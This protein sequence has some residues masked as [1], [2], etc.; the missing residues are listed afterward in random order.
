MTQLNLNQPT[1]QFGTAEYGVTPG[2]DHC[3][4]CHQPLAG[5]YYS[6]RGKA[7]CPACAETARQKGLNDSHSA[8]V[9]G[10]LF[11]VGAAVAGLIGYAVISIVLQ[12][13]VI[14]YMSFGVGWLVGVAMMKGSG[15]VGGR[16]Y[17]IAAVLLTYAA[18]SI[19]AIPIWIY[20]ARQ[21]QPRH[22][23]H[24]KVQQEQQQDDASDPQQSPDS[25]AAR[26]QLSLGAWLGRLA[27]Y[28][29]ASPFLE[30]QGN[31][32]WGLMG[33]V[34]LFVGMKIAW[35]ITAGR[36]MEISGPFTYSP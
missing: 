24:Q 16:R 4:F 8:Y 19:A 7:A 10:I 3:Q 2:S 32:F 31:A 29:L 36:P 6:V 20:F 28:G 17:Q 14:S 21:E 13:W 26:P 12:G 23:Q 5:S 15:G 34:I 25:K 22:A 1:P 18:V 35:K 9:R 27:L 11:G 33:L 30:L